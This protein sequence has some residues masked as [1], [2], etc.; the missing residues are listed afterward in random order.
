[1]PEGREQQFESFKDPDHLTAV[2]QGVFCQ[3]RT[4]SRMKLNHNTLGINTQQNSTE[5]LRGR[6]YPTLWYSQ[7]TSRIA[8]R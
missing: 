7:R 1:M 8:G 4:N 6:I 5:T 3:H 2:V